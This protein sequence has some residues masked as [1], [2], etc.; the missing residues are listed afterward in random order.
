MPGIEW[1]SA[2][3]LMTGCANCVRNTQTCLKGCIL[4]RSFFFYKPDL[5]VGRGF[6]GNQEGEYIAVAVILNFRFQ[7]LSGQ[8]M[9]LGEKEELGAQMN[10]MQGQGSQLQAKAA[11]LLFDGDL[12]VTAVHIGSAD[13]CEINRAGIGSRKAA[14]CILIRTRI[15]LRLKKVLA[16]RIEAVDPIH[17][18]KIQK[19]VQKV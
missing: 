11:V 7:F 17:F 8:D 19:S 4:K 16:M 15:R 5:L 18:L 1:A 12:A 6:H 13:G 10:A 9:R 2:V 14:D 3:L